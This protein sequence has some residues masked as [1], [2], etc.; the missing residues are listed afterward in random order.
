MKWNENQVATMAPSCKADCQGGELPE[1]LATPSENNDTKTQVYTNSPTEMN[2]LILQQNLQNCLAIIDSEVMKDYIPILHHCEVLRFDE[3]TVRGLQDIQFFRIQELVYQEDEFS[4]HKLATVFHVLSNK[5]CTLVLMIQSDGESNNFFL[6][7]RPRNVKHSAGTMRKALEQSLLGLFPGSHTAEYRTDELQTD[8]HRLG[9]YPDECGGDSR[10]NCPRAGIGC[11]SSVSCIADYKQEKAN[12][13]NKD[14]FQ[15]LEKFVYSMQGKAFI[16]IFIANNLEH[17]DLI[18]A[19]K[20]LERIYTLISPFSNM[21][22]NYA[23]SNSSSTADSDTEGTA[24][25]ETKN[26]TDGESSMETET[27]SLSKGKTHSETLT[28]TEGKSETISTGKNHTVGKSDGTN[29]STSTTKTVGS[30]TSV[31]SNAGVAIGPL[32]TGI[33]TN[34]GVSASVSRA[35]TH[36]TSHTDSVSDSVS[37]SLTNGISTSKSSGAT[38][39]ESENMSHSIA[40]GKG[41]QHSESTGESLSQN[42]A[43]TRALTDTFGSSQAVTLN[44]QNKSLLSVLTRLE[45]LLVRLDEC[46]SVGMWDFAAFFLGESAAESETAAS[47]YQS[48][49]SGNQSGLQ[50][51]AVNTWMDEPKVHEMLKYIRNF[52][53][54]VFVNQLARNGILRQ[55]L[56]DST[57]L[58]ST[59]ELAIQFGLPRQ[60]VK[61]LPVIEHASFAQEILNERRE[62]PRD[63]IELGVVKH[64]GKNMN[65]AVNLDLQSLAMHTFVTGSTGSGKSNTVFQL[66][67]ELRKKGIHF[68]VIEPAKGEYKNVFGHLSNVHVYGTNPSKTQLLRI[69]PFKFPSDIHILEHLDRLVEIFNVAW[70]MYAAMPAVLKDSIE[71]AYI[72]AGWDLRKSVNRYSPLLFPT[73]QDVFEQIQVVLNESDYSAD[74]KGDYTGALTTRLKSLTNGLNGMIFCCN[75]IPDKELFDEN[76]IID[77][78]RVGSVETKSLIMGLLVMKLQE[79]RLSESNGVEKPLEHV[80]VLEEAHNL[81]KRTSTEQSAESSNLAGKSVEML[82]NAI[83]EMRAYGEG[84]IIADQAP[85]LMDMSVIRNTN[86]K[87]ILRLPDQSDRELVGRAVGLNDKQIIELSKLAKGVAAVYQNDWIEAV[88]CQVSHCKTTSQPYNFTPSPDLQ[89]DSRFI[90]SLLEPLLRNELDRRID[91]VDREILLSSLPTQFKCRLSDYLHTDQNQRSEALAKVAYSFFNSQEVMKKCHPNMSVSEFTRTALEYIEPPLDGFSKL[92]KE[93]ALL[94]IIHEQSRRDEAFARLFTDYAFEFERSVH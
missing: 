37:E 87:I 48:L 21:Q 92:E 61:G 17:E 94:L 44:V 45:R 23:L 3:E 68:L 38:T 35:K 76:V 1:E 58:A 63:G 7:V 86:T 77:L 25:T 33:S 29:E 85:G 22:Y 67:G 24:K 34:V 64:L 89:E 66:L 70:P 62:T 16:S 84:F 28:N 9:F 69:N 80:T 82:A 53:H 41:K 13:E 57:V 46:E 11:I 36:G 56:V 71:R 60:S 50:I 74:N 54:P 88:L 39:G 4:V 90:Q 12:I 6:G 14:F 81:L 52:C 78:S 43:H 49:I 15:G 26:I 75:D 72:A 20:E 91:E 42:F 79:Y 55:T 5:P 19:R 47:M 40:H 8:L 73:F 10:G 59:N 27:N 31:G 83:A 51:A 2:F 65:T 32:S 93:I 18:E 30:F